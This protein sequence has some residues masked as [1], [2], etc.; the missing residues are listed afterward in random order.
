MFFEMRFDLGTLD[1]GEQS[2]PFG[3]L[4]LLYPQ[5]TVF[6]GSILTVCGGILFSHCQSTTFWVFNILKRQRWNY[7]K[8]GKHIDIHKM[9]IDNRKIRARVQFL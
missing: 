1:S 5:Q 2:L 3:L 4:V 6:M 8:F 9:N 7:I